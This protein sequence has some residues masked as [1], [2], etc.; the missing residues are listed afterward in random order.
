MFE[1]IVLG[2]RPHHHGADRQLIRWQ[3]SCRHS[4]KAKA[5]FVNKVGSR[6][7]ML[8]RKPRDAVSGVQ[9]KLVNEHDYTSDDIV[10]AD[11]VNEAAIEKVGKKAWCKKIAKELRNFQ[12][13]AADKPAPYFPG[14]TTEKKVFLLIN[15]KIHATQCPQKQSTLTQTFYTMIASELTKA[16][17]PDSKIHKSIDVYNDNPTLWCKEVTKVLENNDATLSAALEKEVR[18]SQLPTARHRKVIGLEV[19]AKPDNGE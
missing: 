15:I 9:M 19:S 13:T 2:Y 14:M 3:L 4:S 17:L 16:D 10:A 11:D 12:P 5:M 6:G 18:A 8:K 7:L 1:K